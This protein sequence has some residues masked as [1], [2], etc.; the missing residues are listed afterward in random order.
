MRDVRDRDVISCVTPRHVR[1]V[2]RDVRD[3]RDRDVMHD[4]CCA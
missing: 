3:V 2:M 4:A 1:D